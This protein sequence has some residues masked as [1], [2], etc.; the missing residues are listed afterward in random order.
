MEGLRQWAVAVC[1]AAVVCTLLSRL[2]P[3]SRL[4]QQ[5][6]MLLPCLFLCVLLTPISGGSSSVKLP[7]FTALESADSAGLAAQMQGQLA[8]Q[9]NETLLKMV[10]QSLSGYGWSAKK[11]VADMD[12]GEDGSIQMGQ[13][14]LYVDEKVARRAAAVRQVAEKRLGTAVE[15]AVWQ[16]TDG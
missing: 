11:V 4:G 6:R 8:A 16:E 14:T 9:V 10:N 12:I 5:G 13:I 3:E 2:F 15:V 1:A 7:D